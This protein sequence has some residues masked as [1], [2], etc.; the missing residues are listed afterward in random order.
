MN[1]HDGYSKT[2]LDSNYI[3]KAN[4]GHALFHWP[5]NTAT[6]YQSGTPTYVWGGAE[7]DKYYLYRPSEFIV[8]GI[9]RTV[10][11]G[12]NA[13]LVFATIAANDFARINVGGSNNNGYLELATADDGNEPIYVRQYTGVFSNIART[14]TLLDGSGNSY[15][16]GTIY[17]QISNNDGTTTNLAVSYSNHSHNTLN[18]DFT[19]TLD[20][21]TTNSGWSM[22]EPNYR[23]ATVNSDGT[24]SYTGSY[25]FILK[26]V[27]GEAQAPAWFVSGHSAGIAFGGSDTKGVISMTYNTPVIKIAGGNGTTPV[28]WIGLSGTSGTSYN[29][30][31]FLTAHQSL[32]ECYKWFGYPDKSNM[33]DIA[34]LGAS[35]GM[36]SL[37]AAGNIVDNPY[38]NDAESTSWHLYFSTC[39][40]DGGAGNN[41]WVAQIANKAGTEQWWVRSRAGGTVTNGS[42]WGSNW[43]H[44]VT[45]SVT[46]IG[47]T[48]IPVYVDKF[49]QVQAGRPSLYFINGTNTST[50]GNWTGALPTGITAYYNGMTIRYRLSASPSGDASLK[51]GELTSCPVYMNK[52]SR[53]TTHYPQGSILT[54]TYYDGGWYMANYDSATY[55]QTRLG[56]A[57]LYTASKVYQNSLIGITDTGKATP[58]SA[59]TN[60]NLDAAITYTSTLCKP[61][62][63]YVYTGG[64]KDSGVALSSY[65]WYENKCIDLRYTDNCA[66]SA[67]NESTNTMSLQPG[68]PVYMRVEYSV[69]GWHLTA[70]TT[71]GT[72][73][74]KSTYT[75]A[76]T[77]DSFVKGGY[78]MY[79]GIAYNTYCLMMMTEHPI[80]YYDKV[81]MDQSDW[82]GVRNRPTTLSGY[83]ITDAATST[84]TH[85]QLNTYFNFKAS[86]IDESATNL[87][88][89]ATPNSINFYRNGIVIP[90]KGGIFDGGMFRVK[91][92]NE[93]DTVCEVATWDDSG[94]GETI[95]FNYYPTNSRITPT[96]SVSVPKK[97]GTI[98]ISNTTTDG[99]L[100]RNNM[101]LDAKAPNYPT[102]SATTATTYSNYYTLYVRSK[103]TWDSTNSKSVNAGYEYL[104]SDTAY[105]LDG[106]SLSNYTKTLY[107]YSA[108]ASSVSDSWY[109]IAVPNW[110]SNIDQIEIVSDGNNMYGRA[111][112]QF[113]SM[114][115]LIWGYQSSYNGQAFDKI[116]KYSGDA[117]ITGIYIHV[118]LNMTT[119]NVQSSVA[120]TL[121]KATAPTSY[122]EVPV[123]IFSLSGVKLPAR[124]ITLSGSVTGSVSF[125]GSSNVTIST[126]TNHNHDGRYVYNYGSTNCSVA[127]LGDNYMGMTTS[128]GIDG[129]WWHILSAG[130]NNEYRWNSQIGFP[131]QDRSTMYFRSGKDDNSG[132]GSW[133]RLALY[134]EI[135]TKV[136]QLS[137]DSK[138]I[139][140]KHSHKSGGRNY[141]KQSVGCGFSNGTG[142]AKDISIN[143]YY[144]S[145]NNGLLRIYDLGFNGIVSDWTVSFYIKASTACIANINLCDVWADTSYNESSQVSVTTSYVKHTLTFLNV[146]S[147]ITSD[148]LNGF[149]DIEYSD[150]SVVFYVKDLKIERGTVATD[151]SPAPED[152][153]ASYKTTTTDTRGHWTVRIPGIDRLYDG[154]QIHVKFTTYYYGNGEGYNTINVNGLGAKLV[155][156]RQ[157]Q[158]L[159]SH[160]GIN[161]ELT[162]TYRTSAGSY[163][164][165]NAKGEL[166]NGTTYSDG[167]ICDYAYYSDDTQTTNL[168]QTRLYTGGFV[169]YKYKL[170]AVNALGKIVPMVTTDG[171]GTAKVQLTEGF[172]PHKIYWYANGTNISA[173]SLMPNS[174][175]SIGYYN[176]SYTFNSTF[177]AYNT[178][179]LVGNLDATTGLFTLDQTS[180]TSWYLFVPSTTAFTAL[181]SKFAA[182][183][184]YIRIGAAYSDDN[185]GLEET[186]PLFYFDGMSLIPVSSMATRLNPT[187]GFGGRNLIMGTSKNEQTRAYP[188]SGSKDYFTATTTTQLDG[189]LYTLSFWAKSTV[190]GDKIRTYF[191]SPN[192]T[193]YV[194]LNG[195]YVGNNSDGYC[196]ITLTTSWKKYWVT[197]HQTATNVKK[198]IICPR[199]SNGE[200]TGTIYIKEVKLEEG[201][202]PTDWSPAPEDLIQGTTFYSGNGG[203]LEHN[204]NNIVYNGHFYYSSNGPSKTQGATTDD[205]ALYS[206]AYSASWVGQIAQDYRNGRLFFR[207]KNNNSWTSWLTNIDSG[208]IGSQS[209]ANADTV[210]N[211][212]VTGWGKYKGDPI[213][214]N[215]TTKNTEWYVELI[216]GTNYNA[217]TDEIYIAPSYDNAM[218]FTKV[219]LLGNASYMLYT[220]TY[221]GSKLI[222]IARTSNYYQVGNSYYQRWILKFDKW[223]G[224]Y[225]SDTNASV[226]IYATTGITQATII[227]A[228]T[229]VSFYSVTSGIKLIGVDFIGNLSGNASSA[230]S[231]TKLTTSR[232][233]WGQSFNGTGDVSGNI[234]N[235]GNIT[236]SANNTYSLGSASLYYKNVYARVLCGETSGTDIY[237]RIA[238]GYPGNDRIDFD[239]Y[240]GAFYFNKTNSGSRVQMAVIDSNGYKG[241][242]IC[243]DK[244]NSYTVGSTTAEASNTYTRQIYAR[245]LNASAVYTGD[246]NLYIG[247]NNTDK[248]YF[249]A[250]TS[251]NGSGANLTMS[252]TP[253]QVGINTS[254]PTHPL[255]VNGAPSSS[256]YNV[257]DVAEFRSTYSDT[258]GWSV[259]L[260]NA[261][262]ANATGYGV[263]LK[264]ALGSDAERGKWSGI[265]T[266]ADSIY[267][268]TT[269][270]LLYSSAAERI[271]ITGGGDVGIGTNNPSYK[272]HV[273]GDI[274]STTGFKKDG[275]DNNYVLLGGGGHKALSS[276]TVSWDNVTG[277]PSSFTPSGHTHA[278]KDITGRLTSGNEFNFVDSTYTANAT[279]YFNYLPIDNRNTT[280]TISGYKF[281]NGAKHLTWVN[282]SKFVTNGGTVSQVVL[283]TGELKNISDLNVTHLTAANPQNVSHSIYCCSVQKTCTTTATAGYAYPGSSGNYQVYSF[284]G[285]KYTYVSSSGLANLQLVRF[286]W[287]TSYF[288]ELF[289]SPNQN[290]LWYRSVIN[291]SASTWGK[292]LTSADYNKH[293]SV[294]ASGYFERSG[295]LQTT[296]TFE[297]VTIDDVTILA[298][299]EGDDQHMNIQLTNNST[300]DTLIVTGVHCN[301]RSTFDST[302]SGEQSYYSAN[303]VALAPVWTVYSGSGDSD[304]VDPDEGQTIVA[305]LGVYGQNQGSRI[306]GIQTNPS[307]PPVENCLVRS[308]YVTIIGYLT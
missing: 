216:L 10:A 64:T 184:Y 256:S 249:Y 132:W 261:Y 113:G 153:R 239:E 145:T 171:T 200:G 109:I 128:S 86:D 180:T 286:Q 263:G 284:P 204:A 51:L 225:A 272:L 122:T 1:T 175:R 291:Q 176:P 301:V 306:N 170:C 193:T 52:N 60:T 297:G 78:Y 106:Y 81:L 36:T 201:E 125:D 124:T 221:N 223:A 100:F 90:Q 20:N 95:Q 205:G 163:K 226:T 24:T 199:L 61:G 243:F 197:Y 166:T 210:N 44:L 198:T 185:P 137:N 287:G 302:G 247:Y 307:Y 6:P 254:A 173:N 79:I 97:T 168:Y 146:S 18:S 83:G 77:Q 15:F 53:V 92:S 5:D 161:A 258:I 279:L 172:R 82:N 260:K 68:K 149:F 48:D 69:Q 58:L 202:L 274:Y 89:V 189:T 62:I 277:K 280:V 32:R 134:S 45:S 162:L 157:G 268:N 227:S 194:Y 158:L 209:V 144:G 178:A 285:T 25:G 30:N 138:Y 46:G 33:N 275:S 308:I 127:K 21:T 281:C 131:T 299:I 11:A 31:S 278:F 63:L 231:A 115:G 203:N 119:L 300:T 40:R 304:F 56:P 289:M 16:P 96:Y 47:G 241:K 114:A 181:N 75:R 23:K 107:K 220:T 177:P 211:L 160:F 242:N 213:T 294:I 276:V 195:N 111:V 288:H 273:V 93:S 252:I 196:A 126:T 136:S 135:P 41:A 103:A 159:T 282:A 71:A 156:W 174:L 35:T 188:S 22:I 152:V 17:K 13:N 229:D 94:A 191:Y 87:Q 212:H 154:L 182:G 117:G 12:S 150:S 250:G 232:T 165:G 38:N 104:L 50:S 49:G 290:G 14:L 123:G 102:A 248:T 234:S 147:Y 295:I 98:A 215:Y 148:N 167:W 4:G 192:T 85:T 187:H 206:Q 238:I 246:H 116:Q 219:T 112:V 57:W 59:K 164:V 179:Y 28:W 70:H 118:P 108:S 217:K 2:T 296:W 245:H 169:L 99:I 26:S 142:T 76:W 305:R 140:I 255:D 262:N 121:T 29:L 34:R 251:T 270:L 139:T 218:G 235:T 253:K 244:D 80:Y 54:L 129:N 224:T 283:G 222:G 39:Y 208:N 236:P 269:A 3:L 230:T 207:G 293:L 133:K 7:K 55:D 257:A 65:C 265:A 43:R 271:R 67:Y 267:A 88:Y 110:H 66:T 228:P 19:V 298:S 240:G 155:W 303:L 266:V 214:L 143:G 233:L 130:W 141:F 292:L 42:N 91:G 186:N 190:A 9:N 74:G 120:I 8:S 101:L 27:R 72:Y 264:L 37:S 84:H 183:K 151:W 105:K 237:H 259:G 73:G